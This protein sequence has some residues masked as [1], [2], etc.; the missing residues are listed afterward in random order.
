MSKRYL[1]TPV[2]TIS[3]A[4]LPSNGEVLGLL[5][6]KLE[7]EKRSISVSENEVSHIVKEVWDRARIPIQRI[8]SVVRKME[9][10]RQEYVLVRKGKK[11]KRSSQRERENGFL[12]KMKDLFDVA[13]V[14]ALN[15]IT[16]QEDK[17]FLIAQREPG[18]RGKIGGVDRRQ[19]ATEK[20]I[21]KRKMS[22]AAYQSKVRL[23]TVTLSETVD[24]DSSSSYSST[25]SRSSTPNR[26]QIENPHCSTSTLTSTLV[27]TG[28]SSTSHPIESKKEKRATKNIM[29]KGLAT[30]LDRTK[31]SDRKA[32]Y[33]LTEAAH[34]LGHSTEELN[35]NRS[36]IRRHRRGHRKCHSSSLKQS[37][38]IEG[39]LLVH[40]D[41]KMMA[42]L[43]SKKC[44]DRLPI[45]VSGENGSQLLGV[46]KLPSGSGSN[47]AH[48]VVNAAQEWGLTNRIVGMSFDT[49]A[50]NTGHHQ[51][52]C[53]RIE[54]S[55]DKELLYFPCRHHILELV[56]KAVF[57]SVMGSTA[58]PDVPLF[59]RFQSNWELINQQQYVTGAEIEEIS[60]L[61]LDVDREWIKR[62]L[63]LTVIRGDYKELME[64]TLIFIG[65]EPC[66]GVRFQRPGPMHHARWMSKVIYSLKVWMFQ[67][68]FSLTSK[69]EQ[70][71]RSICVFAA[72]IYTKAWIKSPVASAAPYNDFTLLQDLNSYYTI[73]KY[74]AEAALKKMLSHLWYLSEELV[75]MAF[76]DD[77][78]PID[79][80]KRMQA[81]IN[82]EEDESDESP[83]KRPTLIPST[84]A[85]C[86]LEDFVTPRTK[87]FFE[88]LHLRTDFLNTDIA[89]WREHPEYKSA[90]TRVNSLCVTN[91][92][93]ERSVALIKEYNRLLTH[94]EEQLQFLLQVVKEHRSQYPDERKKTLAHAGQQ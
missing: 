10:L 74:V 71:L 45:L 15:K 65:E 42:D 73:N 44:I 34:S 80:K 4:Q 76:F 55:L 13:C 41:G 43:T 3:G 92:H 18:R 5:T 46:P 51:G 90:L 28:H 26:S 14:D 24:L 25:S 94:D 21:L 22:E 91:D 29:T 61:L 38:K 69:E 20:R 27:E 87:S 54:Q 58:G 82:K 86:H 11:H 68:Q 70:G 84:L 64:L 33:I 1:V 48:N 79:V 81:N 66:R 2:E 53:I 37:I 85:G 30:S 31:V 36:S 62:Q 77:N 57:S 88:K 93:S 89:Q 35:I 50:T 40:W 63:N 8:D 83:P 75:A 17:E 16:N 67:N 59:H 49:T 12:M 52:A 47:I 7:V 60:T 6:Y 72:R 9:K 32:V 39:P 78:V 56:I 23:E 19:A